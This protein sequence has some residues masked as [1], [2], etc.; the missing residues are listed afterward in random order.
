MNR[1]NRKLSG[2][3]KTLG[4]LFL[5]F[6]KP[7]RIVFIPFLVVLFI[8]GILLLLSNGLAYLAPF[9]YTIF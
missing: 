6:F 4:E 2:R 5:Y 7:S 9:V 1:S 3:L 8:A